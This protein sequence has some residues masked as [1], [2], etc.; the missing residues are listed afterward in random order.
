M[1]LLG[2]VDLLICST[3]TLL[4]DAAFAGVRCLH[5]DDGSKAIYEGS[6][7]FQLH[8]LHAA[9][10]E[11]QARSFASKDFIATYADADQTKFGERFAAFLDAPSALK[12]AQLQEAKE[13]LT[14]LLQ[15][16]AYYY[17]VESPLPLRRKLRR[18]WA[19]LLKRSSGK[20]PQ[21]TQ[22]KVRVK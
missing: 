13:R 8:E 15:I 21:R 17:L 9:L 14:L 12:P 19:R 2:S 10:N 20:L 11:E 1:D 7:R 18:E 22:D 4:L 5:Y 6:R 16:E 3:S